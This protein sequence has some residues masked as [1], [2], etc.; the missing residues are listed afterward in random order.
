MKMTDFSNE[1]A[2]DRFQRVLE[3][4]GVSKKLT[5]MG[6]QPGDFVH[7]AGAE[8]IWDEAAMEAERLAEA[9]RLRR[10]HR[11]RIEDSYGVGTDKSAT[12]RRRERRKRQP[13][14]PQ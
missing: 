7:I 3:G 2:A 14:G 5:E 4:S 10:T 8:L 9:Q 1:E 13:P 6:I 12:A 11:Q